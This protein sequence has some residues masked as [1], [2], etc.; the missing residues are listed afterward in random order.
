MRPRCRCVS[1]ALRAAAVAAVLG[2]TFAGG[3]AHA[4]QWPEFRHG[5]WRFVRTVNGRKIESTRC[6]N[7]SEDMKRQNAMLEKAGCKS[8]PVRRSGN[9]YTFTSNCS[10]RGLKS[11]TTSMITVESPDAYRLTVDGVNDGVTTKEVLVARRIG[12]CGK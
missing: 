4:G 5:K 2:F 11:R 3:P 9:T 8:S 12:G 6:L 7:P 10:V 1:R